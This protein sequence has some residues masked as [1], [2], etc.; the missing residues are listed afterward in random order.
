MAFQLRERA[1]QS[2]AE[3]QN[4]VVSVEE[5]LIAK[6]N[7]ARAERRTTFKEEPL[8]IEKKL[9]AII[10]SVHSLGDRVKSVERKTSWDGQKNNAIRNPN[11][12]KN[13]NPNVGRASPDHEIRPPFQDNYAEAS[14]SS[15]PIEDSH[16]NLMGLKNEQHVFLTKEDQDYHDVNQFQTKSGESFDF[17]EGYDSAMY[18][19]HKQYKLRTRTIDV[20]EN[21]KSNDTKQP[22]KVK[23]KAAITELADKTNPKLKEVT[24]EDVSDV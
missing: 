24:I 10:S 13:Q 9:D 17:K 3:M 15:E 19:V 18:E 22:K 5:N 1:P 8:A 14:T 21:V 4:V 11:F 20:P 16:I 6:R 23:D 2:L 7:R 12:R